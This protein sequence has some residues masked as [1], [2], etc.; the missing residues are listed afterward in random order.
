MSPPG[1]AADPRSRGVPDAYVRFLKRPP[2]PVCGAPLTGR[3]SRACSG[4]CRVA[5]HR[6]EKTEALAAHVGRLEGTIRELGGDPSAL[7]PY[8]GPWRFRVAP[9]GRRFG[10][11]GVVYASD[12]ETGLLEVCDPAFAAALR[13]LGTCDTVQELGPQEVREL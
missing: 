7:A 12:R 9:A 2:C 1:P 8:P 4:K 5:L 13:R 11:K 10:W 3:Q 6:R